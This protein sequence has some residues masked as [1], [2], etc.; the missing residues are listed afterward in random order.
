MLTPTHTPPFFIYIFSFGGIYFA[1]VPPVVVAASVCVLCVRIQYSQKRFPNKLLNQN[2]KKSKTPTDQRLIF[3]PL[4]RRHTTA[5]VNDQKHTPR[6]NAQRQ[7]QQSKA[8]QNIITPH[9]RATLTIPY[10]TQK[11]NKRLFLT[12]TRLFLVA[13]RFHPLLRPRRVLPLLLR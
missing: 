2:H 13:H 7:E 3:S 10:P 4:L 1:L 5:H 9:T 12:A 6:Q 11:R 8:K